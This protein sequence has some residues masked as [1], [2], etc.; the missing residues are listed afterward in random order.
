MSEAGGRVCIAAVFDQRDLG[1]GRTE[2]VVVCFVDRAVQAVGW[3]FGGHFISL[4]CSVSIVW[5]A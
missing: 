2:Y 3:G 1:I 5:H 4:S